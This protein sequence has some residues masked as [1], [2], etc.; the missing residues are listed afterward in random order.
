MVLHSS[1]QNKHILEVNCG[2]GHRSY[3]I[4]PFDD[5]SVHQYS[6]PCRIVVA[7]K[8]KHMRVRQGRS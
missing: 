6:Y 3:G 1:T 7:H 2:G 8:H 4:S 5:V